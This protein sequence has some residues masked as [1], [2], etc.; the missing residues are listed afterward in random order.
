[1]QLF[2][3]I[4]S[5][6]AWDGT[7]VTVGSFDGVHRGHRSLLSQLTEQAQR[8]GRRSVV[9]SFSPHPRV[10]LGR[11]EGLELLSGDAEKAKL[12]DQAGVDALLL[13]EFDA[14]FSALSYEEFIKEYLIERVGMAE[15]IIG[16]NNHIGHNGGS[17]DDILAC[18]KR[19]NFRA[20]IAQKYNIEESEVNSTTVRNLLQQG[21][22]AR[23]NELLGYQYLMI[24]QS[25][26]FGVIDFKEPL[27]LI[28]S[29]GEYRAEVNGK[30]Q[31][32]TIDADKRVTSTEKD[33]AVVIKLIE[34]YEK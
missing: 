4:E 12:L 17:S 3:G 26:K 11:S 24:G 22:I 21:Q 15:L 33:K 30:M 10:T 20:T 6:P 28:P 5:F 31:V 23:A 9:V 18:A 13:L 16:F 19:C 27:K 8:Q 25:D 2:R 29:A 32:I 7:I 34:R 1:M 14:A